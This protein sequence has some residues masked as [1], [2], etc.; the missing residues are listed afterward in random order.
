LETDQFLY[1]G[2]VLNFPKG[3]VEERQDDWP[4]A[5]LV[6]DKPPK[7]RAVLARYFIDLGRGKVVGMEFVGALKIK[8]NSVRTQAGAYQIICDP[9]GEQTP[10]FNCAAS[11][12]SLP[13][14]AVHFKD[15]PQSSEEALEIIG[16][17]EE[18]LKEAARQ[19]P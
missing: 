16:E 10:A 7:A 14:A 13:L 12:R 18:Y 15:E 11:L 5:R 1:H 4:Y 2:K 6:P 3:S 9:P 8:P 19:A 17:A